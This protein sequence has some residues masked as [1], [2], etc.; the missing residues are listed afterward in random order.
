[1]NKNYHFL[2]AL[3]IMSALLTTIVPQTFGQE[4]AP[5]PPKNYAVTWDASAL[6]AGG[7]KFGFDMRVQNRN[8]IQIIPIVYLYQGITSY[9]NWWGHDDDYY[10]YHNEKY[11]ITSSHGFG[12]GANYK[13][14][15]FKQEF[16]YFQGGAD[17]SFRKAEVS[18]YDFIPYEEDGLTYYTYD[19]LCEK[20]DF[21]RIS[22]TACMGIQTLMRYGF[23]VDHYMGLGYKH[24]FYDKNKP[25]LDEDVID[26][27]YRGLYPVIGFR[28][29]I[30]F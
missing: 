4:D 27:G 30:A 3:L 16:L 9:M 23:Y 2:I 18:H 17:Y 15:I 10:S 1:M 12:I 21:N 7:L 13:R 8:W 5:P 14:F 22:L 28:L 11:R 26:Y 19:K 20:Q 29:G 6:F 25:A 24:A